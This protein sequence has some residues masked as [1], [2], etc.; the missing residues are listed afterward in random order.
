MSKPKSILMVA[1]EASGDLHGSSVVR[2]ILKRDPSI[3]IYGVGGSEMKKA[4][5]RLLAESSDISVTGFFEI[6]GKI[7][8]IGSIFKT[9]LSSIEICQ[10]SLAILIDCPDFNLRLAKR[11]YR[12]NIPVI[13]YISPQVWAWRRHRIRFIK[14]FISKMLV[15]FPFEVPFYR[16][17]DMDV[18]FVGHP[19]LD[20]QKSRSSSLSIKDH[21]GLDPLK[22]TIALMPG[23]RKSEVKNLLRS[24]LE[25]ARQIQKY[26]PQIQ[27][28][29]PLA[30]T[31]EDNEVIPFVQNINPSIKII[32]GETA[33]VLFVSDI[34]ICCSGTATLEAAILGKPMVVLFKLNPLTYFLVSLFYSWGVHFFALPNLIDAR[35]IVPELVQSAVT[36]ERITQ[37]VLRYLKDED[38][39]KKTSE[40]LLRVRKKLGE[41]G[42]AGRVADE[43]L[44]SLNGV[45]KILPVRSQP[46]LWRRAHRLFF[47][48]LWLMSLLYGGVIRIRRYFYWTGMVRGVALC[49]P[50]ISVGNMTVGGTGKTP[51]TMC[52][53]QELQKRGKK[54]VILSRGYKRKKKTSWDCVSDGQSIYLS[55]KESGDEPR[56]M[57]EKLKDTPIYVGAKRAKVANEVLKR[58]EV[59]LFLLDDGFQHWALDRDFDFVTVDVTFFQEKDRLLPLGRFREPLTHIKKSN[60]MVLTRTDH[61]DEL[62]K[63]HIQKK[64]SVIH[65]NAPIIEANYRPKYFKHALTSEVMQ[66]DQFVGKRVLAF[67]GIGHPYSFKK[68]I[69]DLRGDIVEFEIYPDHFYYSKKHIASILKKAESKKVDV[70]VTTEKDAVRIPRKDFLNQTFPIY[71]LVVDLEITKGKE[72]FTDILNTL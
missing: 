45:Q 47:P 42:A 38:Y 16:A 48:L 22:K 5:M 32:K 11:I 70:I 55:V 34:V 29:L 51:L 15:V 63:E 8:K 44:K 28:L 6:F 49:V 26:Y 71:S 50:V 65:P 69:Q 19:L 27:F 68:I 66:L 10:P 33:D 3:E 59:D 46:F 30:S 21:F 18:H 31:L 1:G 56:L 17:M 72:V 64:L 25:A 20:G 9:L 41:P 4:G 62:E 12:K 2:E 36:A 39:F 60:C 54:V 37:E 23:S 53:A 58:H 43:V 40:L 35:K 52:L 61:V 67:A 14:K 13:Y 57:A 24:L 7:R